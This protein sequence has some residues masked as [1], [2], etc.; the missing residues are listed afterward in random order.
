[1][2]KQEAKELSL[3]AWE[4]LAAHPS[5]RSKNA[6]PLELLNKVRGFSYC[7]PLCACARHEREDGKNVVFKLVD[8]PAKEAEHD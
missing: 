5:V 6:L 8:W 4:Y 1:M 3:E 2:T 7:C